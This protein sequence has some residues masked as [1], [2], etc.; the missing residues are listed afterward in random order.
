MQVLCIEKHGMQKT[1]CIKNLHYAESLCNDDTIVL[2]VLTYLTQFSV[3]FNIS[4]CHVNEVGA[5]K[6][7]LLMLRII[8]H[9]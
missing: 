9:L 1:M 2:M 8:Y 3:I 7:F 4:L 6:L 5:L